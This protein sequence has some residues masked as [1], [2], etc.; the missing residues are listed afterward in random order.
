MTAAAAYYMAETYFNFSRSLL[1]SEQPADLKPADLEEF[2]N[3]LDETAFPF[4]E[5]AIN[6][7]EKN[8][9]LLHDGIF[10]SW[11]EKS[12]DRLTE[13]VPGRY[14]KHEQSA[15]FLGEIE[16]TDPTSLHISD[17]MRMDFDSAVRMLNEEQYESGI[18]LL[19]KVT[20]LAPALPALTPAHID[21]GIAYG[22][23]GDVESAEESLNTALQLDPE[24]PAAY[25][26][27]GLLQGRRKEFKK[28]R[29]SYEKA[30]TKSE[31]FSYAHR[32]LGIVCDLYFGDYACALKH[33][34]AYS[35][36][37]PEEAEV[38]KWIADLRK[39]G[40]KK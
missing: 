36:L 31:D 23:I 18:A 25:N 22:R 9:E 12:L 29:A 21:L 2:K 37:A 38:V 39:R 24:Q 35:R 14:G 33:Y 34:E 5:K 19:L 26:E 27:I 16:K 13:L 28:A 30:L 1:E 8:I 11:T 20:E 15:G 17:E 7:H 6:F 32:N 40:G 10:N 4:E 3:N